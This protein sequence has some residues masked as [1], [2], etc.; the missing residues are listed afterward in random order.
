MAE[1]QFDA[2]TLPPRQE[3]AVP[4]ARPFLSTLSAKL[5]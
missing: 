2:K 1:E 3:Y 5:V 4:L